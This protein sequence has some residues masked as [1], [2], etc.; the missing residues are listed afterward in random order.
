MPSIESYQRPIVRRSYKCASLNKCAK[1]ALEPC[2]P[3]QILWPVG[4]MEA[5]AEHPP[6]LKCVPELKRVKL[7]CKFERAPSAA[8]VRADFLTGRPIRNAVHRAARF[9]RVVILPNVRV[10]QCDVIRVRRLPIA[11]G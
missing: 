3:R 1:R 11:I 5:I 4:I 2:E 7:L 10:V 8:T 6:A 9:E